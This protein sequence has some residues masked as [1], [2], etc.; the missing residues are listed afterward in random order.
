MPAGTRPAGQSFAQIPDS[1]PYEET[2]NDALLR[3]T[4]SIFSYLTVLILGALIS[5]FFFPRIEI[6]PVPVDPMTGKPLAGYSMSPAE[7]GPSGSEAKPGSET[8]K[9]DRT[10]APSDRSKENHGGSK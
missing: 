9:P 4:A 1:E 10:G 7:P 6:V 5:W 2:S 3:L 8:S